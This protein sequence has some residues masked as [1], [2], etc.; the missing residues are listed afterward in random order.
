[1]DRLQRSALII[2]LIERL[3]DRGGWCGETHIQKAVYFLQ[4]MMGVDLKYRFVIYRY[5]PYSFD[6]SDEITAMRADE[7]LRLEARPPYGPRILTDQRGQRLK[8]EHASLVAANDQALGFV[9][10]RLGALGVAELERLAT[11]LFVTRE[12]EVP[13][14]IDAR[15]S[16]LSALKPHITRD[17]AREA[18]ATIDRMFTEVSRQRHNQQAGV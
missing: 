17:A 6:L 7:S 3:R 12:T 10:E 5:G 14:D 16:R 8:N 13:S 9:A 11:A 15:M 1:M 2:A 18:I 4:E